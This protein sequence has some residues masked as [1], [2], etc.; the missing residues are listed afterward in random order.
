MSNSKALEDFRKILKNVKS[1]SNSDEEINA[2]VTYNFKGK[3]ISEKLNVLMKRTTY[4]FG[5]IQIDEG[6]KLTS[7]KVHLDLNPRYQ[8]YSFYDNTLI[9]TGNSSK[10]GDYKIEIQES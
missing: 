7:S 4:E 10:L 2:I 9:I 1:R 3:K 6:N 5:Q 8:N